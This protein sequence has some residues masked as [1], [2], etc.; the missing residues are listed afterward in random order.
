MRVS[1]EE[2]ESLLREGALAQELEI[3]L[4]RRVKF[5]ARID[6][7]GA[8]LSLA[9]PGGREEWIVVLPRAEAERLLAAKPSKDLGT[10]G[11]LPSGAELSFEVDYFSR[12]S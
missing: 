12:R 4:G 5:G 3:A 6:A 10:L 9:D 8:Q 2:L 7:S 11:V 1:R